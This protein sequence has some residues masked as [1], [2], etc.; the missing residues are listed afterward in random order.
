MSFESIAINDSQESTS[1][2]DQAIER[3]V[4][5]EKKKLVS[6]AKELENRKAEEIG[7]FI[8]ENKNQADVTHAK[9]Y[10]ESVKNNNWAQIVGD[11]AAVQAI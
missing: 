7:D 5:E 6:L 3:I 11:Y 4:W 2:M 8:D 10:L 1:S 9:E